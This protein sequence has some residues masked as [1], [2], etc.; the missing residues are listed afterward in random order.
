MGEGRREDGGVVACAHVTRVTPLK[1]RGR[2]ELGSHI[3]CRREVKKKKK[4]GG[5]EIAAAE[6]KSTAAQKE[7]GYVD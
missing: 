4:G 1:R 2:L 5:R 3:I 6:W 7:K